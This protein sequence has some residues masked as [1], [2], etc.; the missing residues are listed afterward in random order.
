METFL[1]ALAVIAM[2][3]FCFWLFAIEPGRKI[4]DK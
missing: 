2:S 1:I 4:Y 3:G